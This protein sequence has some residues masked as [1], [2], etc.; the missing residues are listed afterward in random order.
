MWLDGPFEESRI[1]SGGSPFRRLNAQVEPEDASDVTRLRAGFERV[2]RSE[3]AER[4][5]DVVFIWALEK[6]Y[7]HSDGKRECSRIVYVEKTIDTISRR[8]PSRY[9]ELLVKGADAEE[10]P[11]LNDLR[12]LANTPANGLFYRTI[13][14]KLGPLCVWWANVQRLNETP[15][16]TLANSREWE[17]HILQCYRDR[18]SCLPLKNRRC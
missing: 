14:E 12:S 18:H 5:R 16:H 2:F 3:E 7:R 13:I 17:R 1:F 15:N 9:V 6:E 8:W 10:R 11:D 4:E